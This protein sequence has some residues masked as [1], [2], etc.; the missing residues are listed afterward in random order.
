M[1]TIIPLI[2]VFLFN[3]DEGFVF[4][5]PLTNRAP[6][7]DAMIPRADKANGKIAPLVG[8]ISNYN[9]K[10]NRETIEPIRFK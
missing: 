8:S 4:S 7:I 3:A 10:R 2:Y 5:P 9:S 6:I 1:M